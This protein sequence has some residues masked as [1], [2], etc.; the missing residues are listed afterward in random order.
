MSHHP[1]SNTGLAAY[2]VFGAGKHRNLAITF[3]VKYATTF[4][5]A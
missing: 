3:Y 1:S 4:L 5:L 2:L